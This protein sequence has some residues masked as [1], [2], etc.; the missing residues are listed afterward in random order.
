MRPKR[1]SKKAVIRMYKAEIEGMNVVI[2]RLRTKIRALGSD[3]DLEYI[4]QEKTQTAEVEI[5]SIPYG[6]YSILDATDTDRVIRKIQ[7]NLVKEIA[8]CLIKDN[9][10]RFIVKEQ[11]NYDPLSRYATVAARIDVVPWDQIVRRKTKVEKEYE[12]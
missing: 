10:I 4:D 2:D 12:P 7:E 8:E 1:L 5:K 3:G 11:E 9:M 6:L